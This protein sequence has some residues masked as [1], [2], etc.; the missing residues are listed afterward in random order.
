MPRYQK[1]GVYFEWLDRRR[2]V[3][4][5]ARADIAGFVGISRRGPVGVPIRVESWSQFTSAFGGHANVGLLSWAVE[6]FFANGGRKCW[7]VREASKSATAGKWILNTS[8]GQPAMTLGAASPG[9]WARDAALSITPVTTE[10]FTLNIRL[11]DGTEEVWHKLSA[12]PPSLELPAPDG[13]PLLRLTVKNPSLWLSP[14]V[15]T[16]MGG[17][18]FVLS[19]AGVQIP[20]RIEHSDHL[21]AA[22]ARHLSIEALV[23]EPDEVLSDKNWSRSIKHTS[24]FKTDPHF[25]G[26]LLNDP[27]T[28]SHLAIVAESLVPPA[29]VQFQFCKGGSDG[30]S[31]LKKEDFESGL[32]LLSQIEEIGVLAT[33]DIAAQFSSKRD[34]L[35]S[36][37]HCATAPEAPPVFD[38]ATIVDLQQAMVGQCEELGDRMAILDLPCPEM[39]AEEAIKWRSKFNSSFAACYFP[40]LRVPDPLQGNG[41]V[42][43]VPPSG[44]VAGVYARVE[45][46]VGVHKPPANEVLDGAED[47]TIAASDQLHGLLNDGQVNVIRAYPGRNIR[48]AGARTSCAETRWLFVNVR[49]LFIVIERTIRINLNWIVFEAN[50]PALWRQVDRVVRALLE[51]LWQRGFLDGA[52]REEA[53]TVRCDASTNTQ[54]DTDAGRLVCEIGV[55]PPWPA[56]F[57]VLRVG[58]TEGGVEMG[59]PAEAQV[60]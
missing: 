2:A 56:E 16:F 22:A 59:I 51:D 28:G 25:A 5:L 33:P 29:L 48:I 58:I 52:S 8:S 9:V 3:A 60:A 20:F 53:Y 4:P 35:V 47:V 40:W 42:R 37:P 6:G 18:D 15:L 50:S 23:P 10:L 11:A 27:A 26:S 34:S 44:H 1:P 14:P 19:G 54:A 32:Q 43:S 13:K 55:L 36:Q 38:T 31:D 45:Q 41:F 49:R 30:L 17:I 21:D 7:V 12:Q 46:M 57:V 24:V 39:T